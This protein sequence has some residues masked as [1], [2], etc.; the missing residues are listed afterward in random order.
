VE[1]G[2]FTLAADDLAL[3][4]AV[5]SK[6]ISRLEERLGVRLLHRTTRRLSLT[7]AGAALFEASRAALEKME[8]AQAEIARFQAEP[9]G[10][11]KVSAPMSFG[12]LHLAPALADFA[13]THPAVGLDLKLDDRFVNLVEEGIDVAVRIGVLTDSSLVARKLASTRSVVCASPAYLAEHGEPETPEDLASHNCLLYSYLSTANVWR[14]TAPDGREV[15]VAVTGNLR[16]NNGMVNTEAA[17]AGMGIVMTP[18]FYVADLLRTG[19]L[20]RVLEGYKLAELGI[21][22]VYP[23]HAHVPPKVRVFVD[24]LARRFGKKPL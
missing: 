22:A 2:S 5:V 3:S 7:E 23:Q 15:P 13:R 21:H 4:R 18:T 12:I 24:F 14:F 20:R 9:R 17:L 1:R 19:K 8:E 6:Y 10:R 11:L 16:V